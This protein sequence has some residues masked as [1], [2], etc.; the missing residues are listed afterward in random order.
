MKKT[1]LLL[2][3][4]FFCSGLISQEINLQEFDEKNQE[5]IV[6]GY[7]DMAGLLSIPFAEAYTT[8]H[9]AYEPE[10][11]VTSLLGT[12]LKDISIILILG[13]WCDD[14]KE[15]VPHFFKIMDIL[16]HSYEKIT[17]IGVDREKKAGKV[18]L[19]AYKLEKVPTF[20]F[21]RDGAEIGRITET[22][23]L[24]I[25]KDMLNIFTAR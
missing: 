5:T 21:Y 6:V 3:M 15:Q 25:E 4:L 23:V 19:A 24:S 7:C 17:I 16:G 1:L 2:I 10:P 8:R 12:K 20:I 18:D 9:D 22:P 14:S 11:E 13:A